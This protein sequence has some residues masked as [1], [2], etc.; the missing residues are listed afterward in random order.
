MISY[1]SCKWYVKMWRKRWY[2][3]A[4]FLHIKNLLTINIIIELLLNKELEN[5]EN[6]ELR[7]EWRYIVRHVELNKMCKLTTTKNK[8]INLKR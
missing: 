6:A 2:I 5:E 7:T 8:D 4:F 1:E 3:Y